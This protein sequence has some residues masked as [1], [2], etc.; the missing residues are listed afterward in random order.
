MIFATLGIKDAFQVERKGW[1]D[2]KKGI[3]SL[4]HAFISK[5]KKLFQKILGIDIF[6]SCRFG[7]N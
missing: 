4:V 7:H 3:A 1:R 2:F 5:E 6:V